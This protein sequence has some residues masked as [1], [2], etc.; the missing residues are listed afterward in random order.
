MYTHIDDEK[1]QQASIGVATSDSVCGKYSYR[2]STRPMDQESRD[3]G[4]FQDSD[5]KG[6]LLTEDVCG[7]DSNPL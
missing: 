7:S 1:Y 2:G 5:G 3:I 4:L 6:F